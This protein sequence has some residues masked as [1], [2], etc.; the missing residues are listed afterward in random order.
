[1]N[2]EGD[3]REQ[4]GFQEPGHTWAAKEGPQEALNAWKLGNQDVQPCVHLE[5]NQA[6]VCMFSPGSNLPK[7]ANGNVQVDQRSV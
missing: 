3:E 4:E 5:P 7:F 6:L 2:R 1:M